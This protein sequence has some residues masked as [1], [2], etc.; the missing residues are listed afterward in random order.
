M[1]TVT[2]KPQRLK[3]E[4]KAERRPL[5]EQCKRLGI[6]HDT[7]ALEAR[8]SRVY[9]VNYF[10]GHRSPRAVELAIEKLIGLVRNGKR[11]RR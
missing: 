2:Q 9:V 6:T 10:S 7:I 5:Y 11:A 1:A 3:S 4:L 8:C